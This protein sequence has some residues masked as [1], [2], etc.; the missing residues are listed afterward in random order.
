MPTKQEKKAS[1]TE[2]KSREKMCFK[3]EFKIKQ[4]VG[5]YDVHLKTR[6][7]NL[8]NVITIRHKTFPKCAA[9]DLHFLLTRRRKSFCKNTW[10]R[11]DKDPLVL[12][13]N[14][15]VFTSRH[16]RRIL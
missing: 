9:A 11:A 3:N 15:C 10:I 2:L 5:L 6:K 12:L 1:N 8:I 4:C 7:K 16:G 14:I 13:N